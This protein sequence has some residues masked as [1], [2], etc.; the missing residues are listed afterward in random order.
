LAG[1]HLQFARWYRASQREVDCAAM[2]M[3]FVDMW[4]AQGTIPSLLVRFQSGINRQQKHK[5]DTEEHTRGFMLCWRSPFPS[6]ATTAD[7][8]LH[9]HPEPIA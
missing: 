8:G 7:N 6:L 5:S 4:F 9:W 2:A 3:A 1:A